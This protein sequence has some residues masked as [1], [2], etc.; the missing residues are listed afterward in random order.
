MLGGFPP[1]ELESDYEDINNE[2]NLESSRPRQEM[3][4]NSED[5]RSLLKTNSREN[6]EITIA[7]VRLTNSEITSQVTRA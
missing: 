1:E 6:S 7:T 3:I 4:Q 5:F 2:V